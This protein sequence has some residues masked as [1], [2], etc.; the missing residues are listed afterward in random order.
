MNSRSNA[1]VNHQFIFDLI[2]S[3]SGMENIFSPEIYCYD[4]VAVQ[5]SHT[6]HSF[7]FVSFHIIRENISKQIKWY[8][9][10]IEFHVTLSQFDKYPRQ[11]KINFNENK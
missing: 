5:T 6:V 1:I 8:Q 2:L 3:A 10:I 11:D 4:N 7:T 9:L